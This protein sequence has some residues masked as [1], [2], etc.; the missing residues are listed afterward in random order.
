MK[1]VFIALPIPPEICASLLPLQTGLEGARFSPISNFH[2]TLRFIGGI[3]E[4]LISDLDEKLGEIEFPCFE[5]RLSGISYFGKDKPHS[6]HAIV[7]EN[8]ALNALQRKCDDICKLLGFESDR[9]KYVPHLTLGYLSPDILIPNLMEFCARHALF[10]SKIWKADR[11]Y[12]YS[13]SLRNGPS[14]YEILAEY[15]LKT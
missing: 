4:D 15:P 7:S 6:V 12:L 2:I 9:K 10:K 14:Q 5:L 11:F 3:S 1:R 8:N 13:S